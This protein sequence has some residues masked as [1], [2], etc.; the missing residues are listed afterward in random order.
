[1]TDQTTEYL[2]VDEITPTIRKVITI[3]KKQ[4]EFKTPTIGEFLDEMKRIKKL[5]DKYEGK[6]EMDQTIAVQL[7]TDSMKHSVKSAFPSL[8]EKDLNGM[9]YE[10]LTKVRNFITAEIDE[11]SEDAEDAAGNG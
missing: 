11:E 2:N 6:G 7:M 3:N 9:S 5:Q 1:M 4:H 8:S 10:Q